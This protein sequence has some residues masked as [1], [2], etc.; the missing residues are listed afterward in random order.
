MSPDIVAVGGFVI[1][2]VLMLLR[3]PIGIAMGLIGVVGFGLMN[4]FGPALALL[5]Q[6]PIRTATEAGFG[7]IPMFLLMGAIASAS[8]MSRELFQAA[9]SFLGH[10]RGG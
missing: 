5:A 4:D 10:R 7:V 1:L 3:V 9:N 8:G 6:S 2:F